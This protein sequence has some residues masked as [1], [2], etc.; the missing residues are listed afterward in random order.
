MIAISGEASPEE[1]FRLAQ[2][3]VRAYLAKPMGVDELTTKIEA[4]LRGAPELEPLVVAAVGHKPLRGVQG[5]VRRAMVDQALARAEGNRSEAARLLSV[6]RQAVQQMVHERQG[7]K[8]SR[9]SDR[10]SE[11]D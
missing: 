8:R 1:S 3:G 10:E 4:A 7:R 6:S 5:D 2:A 11:A 9:G